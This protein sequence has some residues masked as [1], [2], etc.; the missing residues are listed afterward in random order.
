MS[1]V[2]KAEETRAKILETALRLFHQRTFKG[3]SLNQIVEEA[4]VTKGALFH[5]FGG[6]DELGYA[7]VD[8]ILLVQI[9]ETWVRPLSTSVDP[10]SDIAAVIEGMMQEASGDPEALK[11]GCPLNNLSQEMSTVDEE[12]RI[13]L[14]R[15]YRIWE[16]S[17][18]KAIRAGK[19]AGNVRADIDPAAMSRGLVA[20][21]EGGIGMIKVTRDGEHM[22]SLCSGLKW[23]LEAMRP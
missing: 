7:V 1:P 12:F 11:N 2:R 13:R 20:V 22:I 4:G 18:E 17:F 14:S 23:M 8:E 21:L 5:H 10:A 19:N 9:T 16:E 3:T 6:K 15:V